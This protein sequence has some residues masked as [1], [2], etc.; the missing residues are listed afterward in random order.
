MDPHMSRAEIFSQKFDAVFKKIEHVNEL[1]Y[2]NHILY[3]LTASMLN[4]YC[5]RIF[6]KFI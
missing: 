3:N 5:I 6:T 1:S 2:A 4:H